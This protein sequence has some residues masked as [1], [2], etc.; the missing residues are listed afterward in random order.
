MAHPSKPVFGNPM[1]Q[2]KLK[3]VASWIGHV[4]PRNF[5]INA[6]VP[7]KGFACEITHD[8]SKRRHAL[9]RAGAAFLFCAVAAGMT[10]GYAADTDLAVPPGYSALPPGAA[11]EIRAVE[12]EIDRTEAA[13]LILVGNAGLDAYQKI[14]TLGKLLLFDKTLSVNR[15]EA[16][17]FCHMPETGWTGPVSALNATTSAYPGS[18]RTRFLQRKPQAYGYATLA[19]TLY[20]DQNKPDLVGGNFWDMRAAGI[21]LGSPAAEQA[22]GPLVNPGEMGFA[23]PACAVERLS[24]GPY[25]PLFEA[26]WGAAALEIQWPQDVEQICSRPGPP[27]PDDPFPVHLSPSDRGRVSTAFDQIGMAMRAYE[28]SPDINAFSSKYDAVRAG[29]AQFSSLERRGYALFRGKARCNECHRDSGESPLFTDFTADN[30]GVPR[31]SALPFYAEDHPDA[32]GYAV[33]PLGARYVDDGVGAFLAGPDNPNR[34]WAEFAESYRGK[35]QAPSL[36]NVDKRPRPDFVK[37]YMHNGYFKSLKEVVHFYNTR[38]VLPRCKPNDPGEKVTCWPAPE[39][40][41]NVNKTQIGHLGLSTVEEDAV[42]AF[43]KTLTD[44]YEPPAP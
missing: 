35:F 38:D 37:P 11:D 42:V 18:V 20:F 34:N 3:M 8:F 40:P 28:A 23:D 32:A 31:N 30:L 36:R 24:S 39:E 1:L 41:A 29:N 19:P 16:C 17:V 10:A 25:R 4:A 22:E 14:T 13:A 33:N 44:G 21:R 15:N 27:S 7:L 43:L 5:R 26:V 6:P 12:E 2:K 9:T